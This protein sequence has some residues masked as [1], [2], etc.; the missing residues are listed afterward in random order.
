[1][2]LILIVEDEVGAARSL[3]AL[4]EEAIPEKPELIIVDDYHSAMNAVTHTPF[5]FVFDDLLL[6]PK[7]YSVRT[8]KVIK[9]GDRNKPEHFS[10]NDWDQFVLERGGLL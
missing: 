8:G 5:D 10:P 2:P 7:G 3:E 6:L 9:E 1:M 4:I